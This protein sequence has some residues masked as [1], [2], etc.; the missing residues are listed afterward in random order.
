M[1][2]LFQVETTVVRRAMPPQFEN[3]SIRPQRVLIRVSTLSFSGS[4]SD[5]SQHRSAPSLESLEARAPAVGAGCRPARWLLARLLAACDS[6][7][8][9]SVVVT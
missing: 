5:R 8:E 1:G 4:N 2:S 7:M 9:R 3:Y 6:A